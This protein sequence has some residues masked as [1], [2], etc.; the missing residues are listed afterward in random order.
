MLNEIQQ[1]SEI[2]KILGN[3][4]DDGKMKRLL[5][6]FRNASTEKDKMIEKLHYIHEKEAKVIQI[7]ETNKTTRNAS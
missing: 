3:S 5:S 2:D 6:L 7:A 4:V 1:Q